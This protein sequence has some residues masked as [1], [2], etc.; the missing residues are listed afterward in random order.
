MNVSTVNRLLRSPAEVARDCKEDRD[1]V[2]LVVTALVVLAVSALL[3][4]AAVGSWRG[5]AQ[6]AW[7]ALKLPIVTL[8]TLVVCVPAFH[9]IAA[10]FGRPWSL[11]S[12]VAIMLAGGARFSLVLLAATPVVWLAI[13]LGAPYDAVKLLAALAY[14]LGGLASLALIVRGLGPGRGR[15][16]TVLTFVGVFLLVGGQTA[17]ILRPYIG[18]PGD[19]TVT[20]FTRKR[21][22]GVAYQLWLSAERVLQ[23]RPHPA[24][25]KETAP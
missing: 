13:N 24:T 17:W 1:V 10:V 21:E 25:P 16:A 5:G 2:P 8:G 6:I 19:D 18:T 11:R 22:G 14:A 3:F 7:A 12:A 20:L 23:G 9:A 4:G 15:V